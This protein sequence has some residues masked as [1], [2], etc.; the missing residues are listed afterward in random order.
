MLM[1]KKT[2]YEK[3]TAPYQKE[4]MKTLEQFIAINSVYDEK[5]IN[6]ENP[7]GAGVSDA[8]N[9]ITELARKDRFEVNNYDNKVVEIL[10]A[11]GEK[12]LTIM[13]HADVV[14]A[15]S[16]WSNNPFKLV[17]K[18]GV[19]YGRGVADDKG[20]LLAAYY[21]F[22]A[23]RDE[24]LLGGY[25]IRFLVGGNEERGS[26]CMEH[27]FK[28]LQ[29][30]QPTLG[31]S[32]DS[33][34]PLIFAEKGI[35][36]FEVSTELDIPGLI[37]LNG[38]VASNAV[39]DRCDLK[40]ELDLNF[41]KYVMKNYHRNEAEIHTEDDVTTVTFI[42]KAAHGATPEM[43]VNAGLMALSCLA[44]YTKDPKLTQLVNLYEPLDGTGFKCGGKSAEMGHNSSNVGLVSIINDQLKMTV[45]FRY[46]NTCFREQLLKSIKSANKGFKVNILSH[47]PILYYP[48]DNKLIKTL[49][50]AYRDE[51]GDTETE[52]LAIGGGTYAKEADNVVAFG[53]QFPG[54]ESNM[55]SPGES[56]RKEDLFKG[57][58]VYARAIIELGRVLKEE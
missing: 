36:N 18:K 20:P 2:F 42:G 40:M 55:H 32:P 30:K 38:G 26:A 54:W 35:I 31:F 48:L 8:L 19:L 46:V 3:L 50:S 1:K 7:F 58:A 5:T 34:F 51:T 45:N 10:Y 41:L 56:V 15:G 27:Y 39:I 44:G 9:F 28:T 24:G 22:K 52:P 4:L 6:E 12:N 16:G 25:E 23:L 13:A 29:K 47:S 17:E 37:S 57:M 11:R 53:M 21:A 43:G 49:L 14:P 33:D